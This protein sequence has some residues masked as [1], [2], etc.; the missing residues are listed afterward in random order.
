MFSAL[1]QGSIVHIVDKTDGL[2]YKT[3]EILSVSQGNVFN[4]TFG[5]PA[6]TPNG[7]ISLKVK[8]G[9]N[10]IDYPEV[11]RNGSVISYNNESTF[12]CETKEGAIT[13]IEHILQNTKQILA[14][15]DIYEKLEKDCENILKELNPTF[16][17]DKERDD[18]IKGLDNKVTNM[19]NKLDKIL[20]VLSGNN[21]TIKV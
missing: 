17:K 13:Q 4:G 8:I 21:P 15:R 20:S 9:D 19:E 1:N 2:K 18:K 14:S 7:T 12:V 6:F 3:G 5:N 16:A 11:P 10:V